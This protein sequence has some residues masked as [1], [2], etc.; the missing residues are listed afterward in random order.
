MATTDQQPEALRTAVA[1]AIW[2]LRREQEDRCD[3]ELEDIGGDHPVWAETD[4]AIAE[5]SR[6]QAAGGQGVEPVRPDILE[7]LTYHQ[8]ERDDLSL[9]E[10]LDVLASGWKK[11]H[12]RTAREMVMQILALLAGQPAAP[13]HVPDA[14]KMVA[15]PALVPLT[16]AEM[17]KGRDQIF[18]INNP[19][20]PCDSK[21]FR[22]VAEWVE[23][24]H[25]KA[26]AARNGL[27]VGGDGG[28]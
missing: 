11:V 15:A 5:L 2:N 14:G 8:F 19:F 17:E 21:T 16:P 26:L 24:H 4:A 18:S 1:R 3:M 25:A 12:G 10:C 9:D 27:T 23:R 13:A 6:L 28:V 7:R 20:C 22:K